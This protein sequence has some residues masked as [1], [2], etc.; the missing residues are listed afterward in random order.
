MAPGLG[1]SAGDAL[2][3][4]APPHAGP[5][6][7]HESEA[8]GGDLAVSPPG[9]CGS[10]VTTR[11][12]SS[13]GGCAP[14][15]PI[16]R[17]GTIRAS[18]QGFPARRDR[19]LPR[20]SADRCFRA[21]SWSSG[22]RTNPRSGRHRSRRACRERLDPRRAQLVIVL[23]YQSRL[24]IGDASPLPRGRKRNGQSRGVRARWGGRQRC[25][26]GAILR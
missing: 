14:P 18:R 23:W 17:C 5:G 2:G 15:E 25:F 9:L 13:P 1:R 6:I 24:R 10:S 21:S 26:T 4:S 22:L 11:G 7:A 12:Y 16:T 19:A 3:V 8:Q 20:S